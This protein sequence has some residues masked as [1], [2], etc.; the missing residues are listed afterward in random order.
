MSTK[1]G[2]TLGMSGSYNSNSSPQ[3]FLI[4]SSMGFIKE[5]IQSL[6]IIPSSFPIMIG[7]F[8]SSHG[9]NSVY[10]MKRII[11]LIKE[12]KKPERSFLV[13][14][15]DLPTNDWTSLFH[16][17]NKDKTYFGLANGRSFYS[18]CLPS[19]SLTIAFTTAS[20]HWLSR[21]PCN[22]SN[23]CISVYAQGEELEAFKSQAREDYRQF[24]ECRSKE[25]IS[26]GIL[27]LMISSVNEQGQCMTE[28]IYEILYKCA[29]LLPLTENELLNY[30]IP[31]YLRSYDECLDQQL[32]N[33]YS[34][35]LIRSDVSSVNFKFYEQLQNGEINLDQFAKIQTG[36]M[37]CA[38]ESII[39]D[40]LESNKERSKEDID[41]LV[42]QFWE[43][44]HQQAKENP[45]QLQIGSH[46]TYVILK[47]I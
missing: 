19:N 15:N 42:N 7:D 9:S 10:I 22:I 2:A 43:I 21:K 34:F 27:I 47:K 25:L 17:L 4:E 3:L 44:Y 13:I 39:R 1:N 29:K 30:T 28:G 5:G 24:L 35:Q 31:V 41:I 11:D 46:Q 14:H 16:I 32:F 8:G 23:H 18:E 38:T 37:R 45:H 12:I 26:G 33:K 6:D 20:I 36:F 40:A